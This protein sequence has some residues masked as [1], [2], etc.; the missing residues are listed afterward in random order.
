[1]SYVGL[2]FFV[3]LKLESLAQDFLQFKRLNFRCHT[4]DSAES[5]VCT[6]Y[7]VSKNYFVGA[8]A[9]F[10]RQATHLAYAAL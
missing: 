5:P 2:R 3:Y 10:S 4:E 6:Y 9:Y 1:M 8:S 7:I